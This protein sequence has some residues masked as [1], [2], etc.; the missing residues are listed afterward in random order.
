VTRGDDGDFPVAV[1]YAT[2]DGT[3][4]AGTDYTTTIGKLE[5]AAGEKVKLF[6]IPISKDGLKEANKRFSL[7]LTNPTGMV[8][9]TVKSAT[10]TIVDNDPGVQFDYSTYWVSENEREFTV[11][12]LRGN[13]IELGAFTVDYATSDA[14]ALAGQD[15]VET[16]G[17]LEFAS[18]ELVKFLTIPILSDE[19]VELDERFTVTLS[20]ST[21]AVVL[22]GNAKASVSILDMTGMVPHRFEGLRILP[23]QSVQLALSG[24]VH[25]RFQSHFDLY[26]LEV[27]TN[28]EDWTSLV[29][30]QRTNAAVDTLIHF[31]TRATTFDRQ[32]YRM[33]TNHLITALL[34]PTGPFPVGVVSRL[35][36]DPSRRNRFFVST[37]GSFMASIWYPAI[38]EAGRPPVPY[39]DEMLMR[40]SRFP[41]S[42]LQR[43]L[44]T[45]AHAQRDARC[46]TQGVPYPVVIYS[47]G[48]TVGRTCQVVGQAENL[49]SHGYVVVSMDHFDA[50]FSRFP[51][52]TCR[53]GDVSEA[54]LAPAGFRDRVKD[55]QVVL[56]ELARWN[57]DDPILA[58]CLEL[59]QVAAMGLSWGGGTAA[60]AGRIDSRIRAAVILD[61]A[62]SSYSGH[63]PDLLQHGLQKPLI[64]MHST[65]LGTSG[66]F[67]DKAARDAV[68]FVINP[69]Q[70]VNLGD[71]WWWELT[72]PNYA[73][74]QDISRTIRAYT[75]WFLN[76]YLKGLDELMPTKAEYPRVLDLQQK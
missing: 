25:K 16:R 54:G 26:P 59:T 5:F 34:K 40:D 67:Y 9:G 11:R 71:S 13:D 35:V 41:V 38:A 7:S 61:P 68:F 45:F 20:H 55:V 50:R 31:D 57:L 60:E 58:G 8:L 49:A 56:D 63:A 15:Y 51:D 18:G 52:G 62:I 66:N 42:V 12:I 4:R 73:L 69:S 36:Q 14:T 10:I 37:N 22:G 65:E 76:K 29:T 19:L 28:L 33:V 1:D 46:A 44:Y 32:F 3:A 24:A 17:T 75:L 21:G 2:A 53:F 6:T 64:T 30:L 72:S 43:S 70:H 39:E 47:H 74:G 48:W 27:S 23:D